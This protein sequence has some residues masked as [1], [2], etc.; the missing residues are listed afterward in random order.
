MGV[1]VTQCE[2][3]DCAHTGCHTATLLG[4]PDDKQMLGQG[5]MLFNPRQQCMCTVQLPDW[6]LACSYPSPAAS[7]RTCLWGTGEWQSC[8]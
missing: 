3:N 7:P 2:N 8:W 4:W 5:H 6:T 1:K